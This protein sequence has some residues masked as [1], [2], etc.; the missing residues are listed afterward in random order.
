VRR[1]FGVTFEEASKITAYWMKTF[2]KEAR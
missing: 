2:G 1:E